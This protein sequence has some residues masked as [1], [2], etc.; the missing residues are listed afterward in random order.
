MLS[1]LGQLINNVHIP[2]RD[3]LEYVTKGVAGYLP[4]STYFNKFMFY[5]TAS[6]LSIL[7]VVL[8]PNKVVPWPLV[9]I[10]SALIWGILQGVS[11]DKQ[12]KLEASHPLISF[13]ASATWGYLMPCLFAICAKN[14]DG[15]LSGKNNTT[16]NPKNEIIALSCSSAL[17]LLASPIVICSGYKALVNIGVEALFGEMASAG[18]GCGHCH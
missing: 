17:F 8:P 2:A 12:L 16:K 6:A 3:A 15:Y 1:K 7:S 11:C 14:I 4:Y 10:P 13:A 5:G 18:T 9:T